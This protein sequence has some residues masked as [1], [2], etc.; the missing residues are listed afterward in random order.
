MT[1]GLDLALRPG[2]RPPFCFCLSEAEIADAVA[3]YWMLAHDPASDLDPDL[4]LMLIDVARDL[5]HEI[6]RRIDQ[7]RRVR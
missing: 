2:A 1:G 7:E 5:G 4:R 6:D 3:E